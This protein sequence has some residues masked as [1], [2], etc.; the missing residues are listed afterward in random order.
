MI[1]PQFKPLVGGYERACE[2]LSESLAGQGHHVV[3]LAERRDKNWS[4][5]EHVSGFEIVRWW[6]L[7]RPHLHQ[8]SSMIGLAFELLSMGRRFDVWHVHQYGTSALIT[9]CIGTLLGKPVVLKLTSSGKEGISKQLSKRT[10]HIQRYLYQKVAAVVTPSEETRQ[11]ALEFGFD[12]SKLHLVGN[13]VDIQEYHPKSDRERA[14]L[15]QEL[16]LHDAPHF[17]FVGRLSWEKNLPLLLAAWGSFKSNDDKSWCLIIVG[18]GPEYCTIDQIINE[19]GLSNTVRLVGYQPNVSTWLSASDAYV[20]SSTHEGLSNTMLEAMAV[21]L[22]IVTTLVS[23]VNAL[24]VEPDCGWVVPSGS[25][26]LLAS[27]LNLCASKVFDRQI[28]GRNAR[29]VIENN[30]SIA[31]ISDRHATL[32][33]DLCGFAS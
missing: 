11:E 3:V 1:A 26:D 25:R 9:I 5:R 15:R 6:C 29:Q 32:Y 22:P 4:R 30:Y 14:Q 19:N 13:G 24:V 12:V 2:R 7:Y 23:G 16:K 18:S 8:I 28:K 31:V 33:S 10:R 20:L 27:A 17:I 21:G